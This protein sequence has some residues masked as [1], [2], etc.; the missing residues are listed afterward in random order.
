[1]AIQYIYPKYHKYLGIY[2]LYIYV[3]RDNERLSY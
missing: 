3:E 1:M 2:I